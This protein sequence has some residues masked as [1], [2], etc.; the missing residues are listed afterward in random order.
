MAAPHLRD[1]L[2]G[3]RRGHK[4]PASRRRAITSSCPTPRGS[5]GAGEAFT[6][7][8]VKDLGYG[9]L[10]DILSG[11]DTVISRFPVDSQRLG[12]TGGSY[13]GYMTMW[14]VTQTTRFRAAV[15][16]AGL[17]NW[18][19]YAGEN[20]INRWMLAYFGGA[21]VY[22]DPAVYA[23]SAPITFI[24][25]ARTP[26]L[27]VAGERDAECPAPQSFEF[28]RGLQ[29][30]GTPAELIVYANEGHGIRDPVHQADLPKRNAGVV[31]QVPRDDRPA[32]VERRAI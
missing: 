30:A 8:N 13:G 9:D 26:T 28:W 3:A 10:R 4:K 27:I 22:D 31:C 32:V 7:G 19:S 25:P 20:G 21:T 17:S 2:S 14:A 23:R 1:V 29:H 16:V 11:V 24:D 5:Y 6:R 15:S 18:L 12:I